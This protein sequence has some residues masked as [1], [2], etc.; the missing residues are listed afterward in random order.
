MAQHRRP[1]PAGLLGPLY[2]DAYKAGHRAA[3]LAANRARAGIAKAGDDPLDFSIGGVEWTPGLDQLSAGAQQTI[4]AIADT[5][6]DDVAQAVAD[7][8][9]QGL[10]MRDVAA[11]VDQALS[12]PY[13]AGLIAVTETTRA[14]TAASRDTYTALGV[15]RY[16]FLTAEDSKV[17]RPCMENEEA[18]PVDL[19]T[20]M[21]PNGD[22]PVHPNCRCSTIPVVPGYE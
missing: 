5:Y 21:F 1:A 14:M 13:R 17:C 19:A 22:P 12:D 15:E 16:E 4:D 10:S 6:G 11:L 8:I 3:A 20:G 2:R 7:G 18:G 9:A